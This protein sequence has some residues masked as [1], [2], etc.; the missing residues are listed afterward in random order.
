MFGKEA[1][2]ITVLPVDK[3][4]QVTAEMVMDEEYTMKRGRSDLL[5][6]FEVLAD[7]NLNILSY[8]RVRIRERGK[9]DDERG[10]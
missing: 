1:D 2:I 3:G 8:Q 5:Y 4:W 10:I 9:I 6:V 7:S